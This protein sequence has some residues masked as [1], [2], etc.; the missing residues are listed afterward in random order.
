MYVCDQ[1]RSV[2]QDLTVQ[3]IRDDFTVTVYE[4]HARV[5]IEQG[6]YQEFNQCQTQLK[7]LYDAGLPG[8][9]WEFTAYRL[10]YYIFTNAPND[11]IHYMRTL[12]E[13]GKSQEVVNHA[14]NVF[15]SWAHG[16]YVAYFK[17]YRNAPLMSGYMMD[18]VL[19][20]ERKK[21]LKLVCKVYKPTIEI[22]YLTNVLAFEDA[23]ACVAFLVGQGYSTENNSLDC[24]KAPN[25]L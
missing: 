11:C 19:D 7:S 12:T 23:D 22:S 20:R 24:R 9:C 4:T 25:P 1:L 5:A 15:K 21:A 8:A 17:L 18:L 2:R 14:V 10:H 6:D 13:E 16:N 3:C